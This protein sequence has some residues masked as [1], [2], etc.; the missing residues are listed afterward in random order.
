LG[1]L[2]RVGRLGRLLGALPTCEYCC[3]QA[4]FTASRRVR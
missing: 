1:R 2:G 3:L 4:I